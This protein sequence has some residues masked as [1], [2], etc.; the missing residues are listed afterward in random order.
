MRRARDEIGPA[1]RRRP[2]LQVG[3]NLA[4]AHFANETIVKD[5][6]TIFEDSP[7]R[8]SQVVLEVTERQPIENLTETRRIIAALQ[9]LGVTIS[10]DDVGTGHSGLSYMLKLG[11]D[12]IKIDKMF[13]DAIG[14]DRNSATIVETLI[15]LARNLRM[16]IVAEGVE[17]FEQVVFLR[18]LGIRAAQGYVF[19]PP[20]PTASFLTLVDAI[21]P[22]PE[23]SL[24]P[25]P[26]TTGRTAAA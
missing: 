15:E 21:D 17:S 2:K 1:Y 16:D 9:G 7:I 6:R 25:A 3:F 18:D 12:S 8:L 19:A 26:P 5:V 20:L 10:I 23:P 4:A 22:L 14:T 11:V 24:Q 13:I